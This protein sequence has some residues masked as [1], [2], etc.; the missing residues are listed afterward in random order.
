MDIL[1]LDKLPKLELS[2]TIITIGKFDGVHC[3]HQQLIRRVVED[4]KRYGMKSIVLTFHP[5]PAAYFA[6]H[7][8]PA[9]ITSQN[10][11]YQL[12]KNLGVDAILTLSCN[13]WLASLSPESY[14]KTIIVEKLQ[15]KRIWIG[16]DF[17]F[18]KDRT[19]NS[20]TLVD[21]GRQYNFQTNVLGPQRIAGS[22]ASSTKIRSNIKAGQ[23]K[24][25]SHLL[26]RFHVVD[27]T[28]IK[29]R[30]KRNRVGLPTINIH[31]KEG[32]VPG[33]GIYSGITYVKHREIASAL[34]VG[35]T[36]PHSAKE[37]QIEATLTNCHEKVDGQ[38]VRLAFIRRL[39]DTR[40]FRTTES[41]QTQIEMDCR[42]TQ[43]EV[44]NNN[45]QDES[46][47]VW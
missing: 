47:F 1:S 26:G 20:R 33:A 38:D 45:A 28:V 37:T 42:H 30:K 23:L 35:R 3:G 43:E 11:K 7:E 22:I 9:P 8:V 27:A 39:R 40:C 17:S 5:H 46:P 19:G 31:V 10:Y 44:L 14:V 4:A 15:A 36:D 6:P 32:M 25:V 24:E 34:R 13:S 21:L 12:I 41:L 16:D 2:Y 29:G 18:G